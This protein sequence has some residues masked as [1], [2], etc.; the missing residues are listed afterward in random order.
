RGWDEYIVYLFDKSITNYSGPLNARDLPERVNNIV[1]DPKK[2][3]P[4]VELKKVWGEAVNYICGLKDDY[5]R[6]FQGQRAAMLS[7]L[8]FNT[9]LT[10]CKNSMFGFS[11]QLRAKLDFFKCSIQYDLEK[12]S[13]QMQYGICE[14]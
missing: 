8:R 12:Y 10:R 11:Q 1:Q 3:L 9:N 7:L 6:L 4:L 2:L 13:D 14:C 5:S